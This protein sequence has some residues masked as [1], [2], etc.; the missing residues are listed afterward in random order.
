MKLLD[1]PKK[2]P[3]KIIKGSSTTPPQMDMLKGLIKRNIGK[4]R[5]Y[6]RVIHK[7]FGVTPDNIEIY[8]LALVHRSASVS[9]DGSKSGPVMNNERL[10]FLG[11]AVIETIVS[12]MLFIDYPQMNEGEMTKLRSRIVSRQTLNQ[13]AIDIG[14]SDEIIAQGSIISAHKQNLFGD[15]FE[16]MIGAL[17]LDKGYNLTNRVLIDNIIDKHIDIEEMTQTERDFK[18]RMIEWAQKNRKRIEFVTTF[19]PDH[20]EY[21][22]SFETILKIENTNTNLGYGS[23]HSKKESEQRAAKQAFEKDSQ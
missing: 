19:A 8:K 2:Q 20:S 21:N 22:P 6:Y 7:I 14:L 18:S 4:D 1:Q 15:A 13:L 10:E 3:Q 12:D 23:G 17:Y 9:V 11:D 5:Y 16:A